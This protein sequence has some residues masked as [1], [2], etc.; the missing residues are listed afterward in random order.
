MK[1]QI[2]ILWLC[3][4]AALSLNAQEMQWASQVVGF[5]SEYQYDKY[6]G[7]YKGIQ[8]LGKPSVMPGFGVSPCA[9]SPLKSDDGTEWL[10]LGF[11]TPQ[12]VRQIVIS[13]NFNAGAI[14]KIYAY[15]PAGQE[16]LVYENPATTAAGES[17][18]L[19]HVFLDQPT[20]FEVQ[21]LKLELATATVKGFNQIDAVGISLS[22]E[23]FMTKINLLAGV[24]QGG[25]PEKLPN[26][27]NTSTDD[28]SPVV[29]PDGRQLFFTRQGFAGNVGDPSTQDIYVSDIL[30]D[31]SFGEAVNMGNPINTKDNNSIL[32]ITPDGQKMLLLN[33]F[34]P[35]GSSTTG[36]SMSEKGETGWSFPKK[37]EVTNLYNKHQYGE[38]NLSNSGKVLMMTIMRDDAIASKDIY[39]SFLDENTGIWSEPKNIGPQVNTA[40]SEIS[41]FLAADEKTLYFAT[42]GRPG[43][44]GSDMFL[45]RRLDDTWTNWSEPLNLGPKLNSSGFDAYYSLAADGKWTYFTS[46]G[47]GGSDANIYRAELPPSLRPGSVVLVSGKVYNK[48]NGQPLKGQINYENLETGEQVGVASSDAKDGHY[49]IVLPAG[50]QYGFRA[51]A[52]GFLTVSQNLDLRDLK[53]YSE[54][55]RDLPLVPFEV[56]ETMVLNNIFFDYDKDNLKETSRLELDR[57][58]AFLTAN[59]S[60]KIEIKGHTDDKGSDSYNLDLSK[61]RS[62][63]VY[64]YL[65][66]KGVAASRLTYKGLGE[67]QPMVPNTSDENRAQ[68]RRVEF[69]I[70]QK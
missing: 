69:T 34:L 36:I 38:Y 26:T 45:T 64:D 40:E 55:K 32:S 29:S 41:P 6:P 43:Y 56:G 46:Y 11:A 15:D 2:F 30:P 53:D 7:Q 61:R 51:T 24:E 18:R 42:K 47:E 31:G 37:V 57:L 66:K 3:F 9:W 52:D 13:E 28:L 27:V 25:S 50:V 49:Q 59:G 70:T 58:V 44:G 68:N 54:V 23:K 1:Q 17:G 48:K 21:A 8:A 39:V 67:T 22:E 14:T 12:K 5:S 60:T 19:L 35:D 33:V 65:V 10:K 20:T 16:H 4:C 62:K 63:S